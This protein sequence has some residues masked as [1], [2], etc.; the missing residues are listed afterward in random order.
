M[1]KDSQE[2]AE[3]LEEDQRPLGAR[4]KK[5]RKSFHTSESSASSKDT[6]E[7]PIGA[8]RIIL[9]AIDPEGEDMRRSRALNAVLDDLFRREDEGTAFQGGVETIPLNL[10]LGNWMRSGRFKCMASKDTSSSSSSI[11]S[12]GGRTSPPILRSWSGEMTT[13][14][15]A[16]LSRDFI[17]SRDSSL[18]RSEWEAMGPRDPINVMEG[19]GS[20]A[21]PRVVAE[22]MSRG[23]IHYFVDEMSASSTRRLPMSDM[24][25]TR[26][27]TTSSSVH[28]AISGLEELAISFDDNIN[29]IV[30]QVEVNQSDLTDSEMEEDEFHPPTEG[31]KPPVDENAGDPG[32]SDQ[33]L[34]GAVQG[35]RHRQEDPGTGDQVLGGSVQGELSRQDDD[36][37]HDVLPAGAE[38]DYG[39]EADVSFL[40]NDYTDSSYVFDDSV[41][42]FLAKHHESQIVTVSTTSE[43]SAANANDQGDLMNMAL[44][45]E[46]EGAPDDVFDGD[47]LDDDDLPD[48]V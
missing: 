15:R 2:A 3:S 13:S 32:T 33:V 46:V 48:L 16:E 31:N 11:S 19:M 40:F 30:D 17:S 14:P 41:E 26:S 7:L 18:N 6:A 8:Q 24:N 21:P 20:V 12:N 42:V 34:G 47:M 4:R 45:A 10:G 5:P 22:E 27:N 28:S 35:E 36:K 39:V 25:L 37:V 23:M 43:S 9:D 1:P 38:A 29:D 44:V